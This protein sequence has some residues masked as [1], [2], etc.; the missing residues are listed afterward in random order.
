M[1]ARIEK[2]RESRSFSRKRRSMVDDA[3]VA[4][5]V[6][7]ESLK[8]QLIGGKLSDEQCFII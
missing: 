6:F 2:K 3:A 7:G 5:V 4:F 1:A 8:R